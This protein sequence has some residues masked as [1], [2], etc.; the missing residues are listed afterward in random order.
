LAEKF[1][2]G[3]IGGGLVIFR[4]CFVE[5]PLGRWY[6]AGVLEGPFLFIEER[7]GESAEGYRP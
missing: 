4:E 7:Y 1:P 2:L 6:S 3:E 5:G